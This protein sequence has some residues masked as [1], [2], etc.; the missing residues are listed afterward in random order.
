MKRFM[1][2]ILW[3]VA[4]AALGQLAQTSLFQLWTKSGILMPVAHWCDLVGG[5]ALTKC[6][7]ILYDHATIWII[8]ICVGI[9]GGVFIRRH[10]LRYLL[11]FSAGFAFVPLAIYAYLHS[12]MPL[13]SSVVWHIVSIIFI[14]A[15]GCIFHRLR[16]PPNT[17]LEPTPHS[18][19]GLASESSDIR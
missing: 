8:A 7:F 18:R 14:V 5:D 10:F 2:S 6:W 3:F 16:R 11:W 17:A 19:G 1:P 4:G 15:C 12:A 9:F 13:S